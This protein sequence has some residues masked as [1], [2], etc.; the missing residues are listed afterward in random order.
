MWHLYGVT[1]NG[2]FKTAGGHIG[3][4]GCFYKLTANAR[5]I[6]TTDKIERFAFIPIHGKIYLC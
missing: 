6:D 4:V 2:K 5:C 3:I 1:A